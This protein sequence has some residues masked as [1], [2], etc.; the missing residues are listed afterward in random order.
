MSERSST[1]PIHVR[2]R[3][4]NH[5]VGREGSTR[6]ISYVVTEIKFARFLEVDLTFVLYSFLCGLKSTRRKTRSSK[7]T[8]FIC[9]TTYEIGRKRYP[10]VVAVSEAI[11]SRDYGVIGLWEER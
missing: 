2:V 1:H 3:A 7:L 6:K 4:T 11:I 10:F 9:V 5:T 8:N